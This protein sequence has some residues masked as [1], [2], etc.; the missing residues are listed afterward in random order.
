MIRQFDD[1]MTANRI[2]MLKLPIATTLKDKQKTYYIGETSTAIREK[3]IKKHY[4]SICDTFE[5]EKS[6]TDYD[7]FKEATS[8]S[9]NEWM[10]INQLNSSTLLAF[11]CFHKVSKDRKFVFDDVEYSEV[12]FEVQ[13]PLRPNGQSKPV[14]NMDVVLL[15][16]DRSKALF[17]ESK[18]TEYLSAGKPE[19]SS[20]YKE[21]YE[22]IF[23]SD[24]KVNFRM[25]NMDKSFSIR[26]N[27]WTSTVRGLYLEGLKQM[28]CHYLGILHCIEEGSNKLS[29]CA[30]LWKGDD[31]VLSG[32]ME[33][34]L[35]AILYKFN[36]TK[37]ESYESAYEGLAKVL[38]AHAARRLAIVKTIQ[39]Y[40][41]LFTSDD[42]D[43]LLDER[44]K[45]FY[46]AMER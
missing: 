5:I 17:L 12:H 4:D 27:K 30:R 7:L 16:E 23:G 38:N 29:D 3:I 41:N 11:L 45:N 36:D 46:F 37:F 24:C 1:F 26:N 19:V 2:N 34:K 20:Y 22:K 25:G 14:S 35:G 32:T 33:I 28:V 10:E 13:S 44:V 6:P 43:K 18:F 39:T 40:Q 42:N 9:G 21:P 15:N 31:K 8:G